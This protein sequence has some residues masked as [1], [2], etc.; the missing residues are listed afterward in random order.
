MSATTTQQQTTGMEQRPPA[1]SADE[2]RRQMRILRDVNG[3]GRSAEEVIRYM[4]TD[5]GLSPD[6][7]LRCFEGA[8]QQWT[9]KLLKNA[10]ASAGAFRDVLARGG[11]VLR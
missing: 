8:V 11:R 9:D 7:A 4:I 2:S 5:E 3:D 6:A 10:R 1:L